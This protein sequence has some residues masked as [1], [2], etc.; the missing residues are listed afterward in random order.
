MDK[1]LLD[2][3]IWRYKHPAHRGKS[4]GQAC[5]TSNPSCGDDITLYIQVND[6]L[7]KSASFDG[8]MCSIANYGAELLLDHI[9]GQNLSIAVKV[10]SADLLGKANTGLLSNPVR[11]KCFELASNALSNYVSSTK[12]GHHSGCRQD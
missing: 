10:T 2:D 5:R 7:L 4:E 11:L 3:V 1:L 8:Q 9:I 6:G 12:Q